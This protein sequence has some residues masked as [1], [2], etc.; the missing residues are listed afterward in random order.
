MAT[1]LEFI[2][3]YNAPSTQRMYRT[4]II[5]FL[6]TAYDMPDPGRVSAADLPI[7]DVLSKQYLNDNR[8]AAADLQRFASSLAG[9]PPHTIHGYLCAARQFLLEND[10][11]ITERQRR[12]IMGRLPRGG[13]QTVEKDLDRA[14]LK[15]ILTHMS[16]KGR[17]LSLCLVSSGARIGEILELELEDID[18]SR[19]PAEITIRGSTTKTWVSRTTFISR[20][21]AEAMREWLK[22]RPAYIL[23]SAART[24]PT[25]RQKTLD[26]RR[27]FPFTYSVA[28]AIW[29]NA[30]KK[31]G[32]RSIDRTTGRDQIHI[33]MLRKFFLSQFRSAENIKIGE[34]LCGHAGY[35]TAAYRRIPK[36]DLIECFKLIEPRLTILAPEDYAQLDERDRAALQRQA[37]MISRLSAEKNALEA[38]LVA[39][40]G[41]V[42]AMR[43]FEAEVRR[44]LNAES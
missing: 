23:E 34:E 30:L 18:L 1:L 4:G 22:V 33:H 36:Q 12:R 5:R 29:V 21:A 2:S 13:S 39:I 25:C 20:E 17:V 26:D 41:D 37:E 32:L 16:L 9:R 28:R 6:A 42:Q 31:A 15:K 3:Y 43:E 40:E 44:E 35:L 8:D 19:D 38:R 14:T 11:E 24:R 10:I 7:Y 27:L